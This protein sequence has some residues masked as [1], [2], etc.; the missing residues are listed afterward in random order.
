MGLMTRGEAGHAVVP[1][2]PARA[3]DFPAVG[4][5][6]VFDGQTPRLACT[7]TLIAP[8]VVVTAAHCLRP[9][10][11]RLPSFILSRSIDGAR[12]GT[13]RI[14]SR[15]VLHP[16]FDPRAAAAGMH[17]LALVFL[18]RPIDGLTPATIL[19]ASEKRWLAEGRE[20]D[21]V[22][23]GRMSLASDARGQKGYGRSRVSQLQSQ[24][25]VVG[26][27]GVAQNC[28]GDS[29]GPAFISVHGQRR[30]VGI[31][32]RSVKSSAPCT[33]G[34]IHTRLDGEAA[35]IRTVL[36]GPRPTS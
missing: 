2:T 6:I 3:S 29:G 26:G 7:G 10:R 25:L 9:L 36:S 5:L 17:D 18:A 27:A 33:S 28:D 32:S 14:A 24:E 15:V 1:G 16:G 22:G 13:S 8:D 12:P 34:T 21:L 35:W 23:Y 20:V 19:A 30:M 4:A 11:Q 31:V